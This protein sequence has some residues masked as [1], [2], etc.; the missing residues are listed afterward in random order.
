MIQNIDSWV[1]INKFLD[2]VEQLDKDT[3][4]IAKIEIAK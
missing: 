3:L 4:E 1:T 2:K